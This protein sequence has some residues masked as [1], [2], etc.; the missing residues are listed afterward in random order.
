MTSRMVRDA[1]SSATAPRR[2]RLGTSGLVMLALA[3]IRCGDD[4][5]QEGTTP[6]QDASLHDVTGGERDADSGGD[7][8]ADSRG[9]NAAS[10]AG[11]GAAI[12]RT[13]VEREDA[14]SRDSGTA[15]QG[16]TDAL[17][18][19]DVPSPVDAQRDAGPQ[20]DTAVESD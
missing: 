12:D 14:P 8:S 2:R 6:P 13:V 9:A 20:A 7:V 15:D 16:T 4:P 5:A 3:A 11:P 17:R 18:S 10:N 19:E 1:S